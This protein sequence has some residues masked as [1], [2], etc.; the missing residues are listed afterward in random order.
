[1]MPSAGVPLAIL[2][3]A[4]SAA[5]GVAVYRNWRARQF[6]IAAAALNVI[7]WVLGQGFGGIFTGQGTDPNAGPL[8]V[9]LAFALYSLIGREPA[10]AGP[11]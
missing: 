6:L 5:I 2:L 9:L 1:M 4:A 10:E 11:R 3:S 8:F 7:Y